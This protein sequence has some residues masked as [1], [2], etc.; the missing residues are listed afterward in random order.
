MKRI[1]LCTLIFACFLC[2]CNKDESVENATQKDTGKLQTQALEREGLDVETLDINGDTEPDQWI[3][4]RD[5]AVRYIQRDF[6]FDGIIDLTEF[7]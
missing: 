3:Y 4:K 5:G 6:N 7:Y 2:S 1:G